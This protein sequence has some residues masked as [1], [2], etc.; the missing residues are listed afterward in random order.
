M[1]IRYTGIFAM[2]ACVLI[3]GAQAIGDQIVGPE[4]KCGCIETLEP[5]CGKTSTGVF[6]YF[7]NQCRM[8]CE[9]RWL[10]LDFV[11]TDMSYCI[12]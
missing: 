3:V 8:D 5:V 9:N 12:L 6:K 10:L 2:V 11:K 1:A 4:N 7:G